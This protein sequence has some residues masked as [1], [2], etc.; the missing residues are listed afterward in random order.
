[1]A[2]TIRMGGLEL[3]FLQSRDDTGG[4]L[5]LFEMTVQPDARMPVPHH[6]ESWDETVVGLSGVSTWR[7]DGRDVSIGPGQSVF[8]RRGVVHGFRNDTAEPAE[9]LCILTPGALGPAYFR[10]MAGLLAA[11]TPDPAAMK[12]VMLRYGLVP[13]PPTG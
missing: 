6:H 7:V 13:A 11:G 9:C 8:I 3:R 5:D 2:E 12:A 1:M 4:S 10:E